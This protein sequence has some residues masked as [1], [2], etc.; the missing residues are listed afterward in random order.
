WIGTAGGLSA[1]RRDGPKAQFRNYTAAN[2]LSDSHILKLAEDADGNLWMG[3]SVGGVMKLVRQGFTSFDS[4]DGFFSASNQESIFETASG[5][6]AIVSE[7]GGKIIVQV[8]VAG[9]FR[10]TDLNVPAVGPGNPGRSGSMQDRAGE[11]WI[12]S[13]HGLFRFPKGRRVGDLGH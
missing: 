5:D 6:L 8:P 1:F 4:R 2:G 10:A 11:W 12:G 13:D 3:S 9:K 7:A